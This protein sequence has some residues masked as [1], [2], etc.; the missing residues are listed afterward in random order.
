MLYRGDSAVIDP[1]GE[2]LWAG[3]EEEEVHVHILRAEDLE[4]TRQKLPF[5]AD[6]DRFKIY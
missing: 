2:V 3:S 5:L 1:M 4:R 6:R